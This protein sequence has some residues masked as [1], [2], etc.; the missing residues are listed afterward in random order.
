MSGQDWAPLIVLGVVFYAVI[1]LATAA[2]LESRSASAE[3]MWF[4]ALIWPIVWVILLFRFII[5]GLVDLFEL[6]FSPLK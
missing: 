6:L 2:F 3:G 5:I 1:G 4:G